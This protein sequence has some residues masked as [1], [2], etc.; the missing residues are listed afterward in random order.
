PRPAGGARRGV[1][2][3]PPPAS[4]T[5][6]GTLGLAL[7]LLA[8]VLYLVETRPAP[9]PTP[10]AL[11]PPSLAEATRVEIVEHDRPLAVEAHNGQFDE[12]AAGLLRALESLRVLA[13]IASHPEDPGMYGC[14]AAAVRLRVLADERTLVAV[15]LGDANPAGTGVYVRRE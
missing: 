2:G 11:L 1:D 3:E 10:S 7:L 9:A 5:V 8:L 4:M 14:G 15:E 6:R 12:A 13:V